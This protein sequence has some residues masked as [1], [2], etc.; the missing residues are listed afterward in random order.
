MII[1][2]R[3]V[4]FREQLILANRRDFR[5]LGSFQLMMYS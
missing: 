2:A 3:T 4:V 5:A 1:A